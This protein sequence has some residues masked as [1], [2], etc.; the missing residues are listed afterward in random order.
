MQKF[1][2]EQIEKSKH[3]RLVMGVVAATEPILQV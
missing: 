1:V 3:G 2:D